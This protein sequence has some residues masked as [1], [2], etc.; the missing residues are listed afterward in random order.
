MNCLDN[1]VSVRNRNCKRM[2]IVT[3]SMRPE[4]LLDV[5][6][7]IDFDYLD[8]WIIVYDGSKVSSNPRLF[9]HS[10]IKEYVFYGDGNTG[11]PQRNYGIE[12]IEKQDTFIYFLDD[13][14]QIHENLYKLL[15]V[16]MDGEFYTFNQ[17]GGIKGDQIAKDKIDTGMYL[18]DFKISKD[19]RW[20]PHCHASDFYYINE[21]YSKKR[22]GWVY[23]DSDLCYYN[24]IGRQGVF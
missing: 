2:T 4:N 12:R 17:E 13:D 24:K 16:A 6:E 10:N 15:D 19:V 1:I 23:V 18:V 8:E 3:P 20:Y 21:C 22:D 14:N 7:S 5:A 11:N 9:N